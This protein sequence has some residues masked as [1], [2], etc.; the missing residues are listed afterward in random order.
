[1]AADELRLDVEEV[2][3]HAAA[4]DEVS[5]AVQSA[6]AAVGSAGMQPDAYG[7]LCGF[8]PPLLSGVFEI[9]AVAMNGSAEALRETAINLRAAVDLVD[10]T[11]TDAA[12]DLRSP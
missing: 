8:L 3:R 12:R 7:V 9:A 5:T 2:G 10:R 11:D 6:R 4:V 1:M